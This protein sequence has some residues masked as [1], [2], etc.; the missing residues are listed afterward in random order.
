EDPV[1]D[2][3]C[4]DFTNGGCEQLCINHP[5]TFNCSCREGFQARADDPT[6]CQRERGSLIT[7]PLHASSVL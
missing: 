3:S 7:T 5:G 6:K 2:T 1:E 4:N